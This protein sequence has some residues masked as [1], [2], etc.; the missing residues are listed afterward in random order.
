MAL[1]HPGDRLQKVLAAAGLC[2]RR[3]AEELIAA[4]RVRVDGR[5]AT[6]G[7]RADPRRARIEVDGER[8]AVNPE[9]SYVALNK[10]AGVVT[11]MSDPQG[12]PTVR[13]LLKRA[14]SRVVPVGRLDVDTTGLLLL[15]NDGA[16]A[17]RLT[18]PRWQVPR[19]YAT[20]VRG[21]VGAAALRRLLAGVEL[22]DGVARAQ[23]ARV[24]GRAR[25]RTRLEITMAEGR[26]RE[27]RRLLEAVGHPVVRLARVRYGPISLGRLPP[28]RWRALSPEEIGALLHSVGL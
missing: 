9:R 7:D 12:R 4:G 11:T 27:V 26:K 23:D 19:V 21:E 10:P 5:V 16:L 2:S 18:H 14:P 20:E 3:A 28:G 6:L 24:A 25:G 22:D 15:T 8:V 17:H 13:D 1:P